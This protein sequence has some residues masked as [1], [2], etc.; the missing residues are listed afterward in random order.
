MGDLDTVSSEMPDVLTMVDFQPGN[1]YA[2]FDPTVDK[3]AKYG[4]A[5]LVAGTAVA[6]AAKAGLLGGLGKLLFP[7]I[8]A[9]KKVLIFI[10]IGVVAAVKK[11]AGA[12]KGQVIGSRGLSSIRRKRRRERTHAERPPPPPS[13][14][15]LRPPEQPPGGGFPPTK[16]F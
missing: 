11:I 16:S 7:I 14:D 3:V 9:L 5:G 4:I 2:E 13:R 1:T 8:L 6:V 15:P 10:V 12:I